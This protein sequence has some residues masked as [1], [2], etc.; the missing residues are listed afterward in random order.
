MT[1]YLTVALALLVGAISFAPAFAFAQSSNNALL[2]VYVQVVNPDNS[3][4]YNPGNFSVLVAGQSPS[5]STFFGTNNG[6]QVSLGAGTYSVALSGNQYGYTPTY[7]Q[8]C[9]GT[10]AAGQSAL[11]V[12]TMSAQYNTY[13]YPT[14]YPYPY[15]YN[16]PLTCTAS[17]SSVGL[18]QNVS[19]TAHGGV[20][21]AYNW[22]SANRNYPN[23]GPTLSI[24]FESSG[25]QLVTVTNASQT[26]TCVVNVTSSY[27]PTYP[28][29]PGTTYPT[30]PTPALYPTTYPNLPN[31]G[32]EPLTVA[33]MAL[34]L[35]LLAGVSLV[36]APYVR[37]AF[38]VAA[39]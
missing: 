18:L 26:A 12:I 3:V 24:S 7:S 23:A 21:G 32:I 39:R 36:A 22:Q 4:I 11:C 6:T 15:N 33:Q 16:N 9:N 14:P 28:T 17:Q 8:G 10:I 1:K 38:A 29:Y 19:F 25:S 31:T 37:K 13:P 27:Y 34:A 35:T 2:S 5:P 30:Y 20:G